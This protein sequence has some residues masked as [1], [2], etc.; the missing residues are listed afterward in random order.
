MDE[1]ALYFVSPAYWCKLVDGKYAAVNDHEEYEEGKTYYYR[2]LVNV[3]PG[4]KFNPMNISL[5]GSLSDANGNKI[6]TESI[7]IENETGGK[8]VT[9]G[10][11]CAALKQV[12]DIDFKDVVAPVAGETP[13]RSGTFV[14]ADALYFVS[15]AY[16]C[17][18][19]G[20]KYTALADNETFEGGKTY[21]YRCLVNVKPGYIFNPMNIS[22]NGSLKDAKGN[23]IKSDS[24][25]IENDA[26]G[27]RVTIGVKC[28]EPKQ[29]D[30]IDFKNVVAP[31]AGEKPNN[32][33]AFVDADAL[34]MVSGPAWCEVSNGSYTVV[35][36]KAFEDGKTY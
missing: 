7:L 30:D 35:N 36:G 16:W 5:N 14:D 13:D 18:V 9:I 26:K 12:N 17:K 31:V 34:R 1:D 6:K 20:G 29:V 28:A 19:V 8:R 10:V 4:Y 27:K 25:L 23:P 21:Y 2:C 33:W 3:K 22:L 32:S 24:I 11:K 15:P